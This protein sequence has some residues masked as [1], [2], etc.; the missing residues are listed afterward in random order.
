VRAIR[1]GELGIDDALGLNPPG[2]FRQ[3]GLVERLA[4]AAPSVSTGV[5]RAVSDGYTIAVGIWSTEVVNGA[6]YELQHDVA[7]D[8]EPIALLANAPLLII[9][10]A[11]VPANDL[12][13]LI[14]WLKANPDKASLGTAGVGSPQISPGFFFNSSPILD[15]S[16]CTI[17]APPH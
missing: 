2:L 13:G 7:K 11:A 16:P 6:I 17:A 15:F 14:A 1:C 8:F 4:P 12:T 3:V 9:A 5:A 10:K